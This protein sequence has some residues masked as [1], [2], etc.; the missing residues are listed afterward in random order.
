MTPAKIKTKEFTRL[1]DFINARER[2]RQRKEANLTPWTKDPILSQFHF[3]NIDREHDY[4]T[5]WIRRH[6]SHG[7]RHYPFWRMT[8]QLLVCRI[9]NEP[10]VLIDVLPYQKRDDFKDKMRRRRNAGMTMFRG[11]YMV[12]AHG[13]AMPAY[14][15]YADV[16]HDA[17]E[18]LFNE[19]REQ[20][21]TLQEVGDCM[22]Q[23]RGIGDFIVN[24]VCADL[25]HTYTGWE[26]YGTFVWGGPGT[27]RGLNRL[28]GRDVK[29]SMPRDMATNL[30]QELRHKLLGHYRSDSDLWKTFQDPNN[31]SNSLCEFDKYRRA[32]DQVALGEEPSLRRKYTPNPSRI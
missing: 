23:V 10:E 9:F 12:A 3:C 19:F 22:V 14:L 8:L 1:V 31:V 26:D 7:L 4:V 18:R 27:K 24:Q 32:Q 30:V 17:S 28:L 15:Y 20:P 6:V 5:R 25:R 16:L 11:A 13:T 29:E 2:L 21:D